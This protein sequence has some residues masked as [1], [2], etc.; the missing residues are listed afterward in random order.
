MLHVDDKYDSFWP[1]FCVLLNIRRSCHVL[2]HPSHSATFITHD[3]I[4]HNYS[5]KQIISDNGF[6]RQS[7]DWVQLNQKNK[8]IKKRK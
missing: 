4:F 6:T 7:L 5:H 1:L 2:G 8:L 3:K